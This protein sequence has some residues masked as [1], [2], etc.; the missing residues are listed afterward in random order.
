MRLPLWLL[1]FICLLLSN[2]WLFGQ[3]V[4]LRPF[5]GQHR[6]SMDEPN[7]DMRY[8]INTLAFLNKVSL[9]VPQDL[10]KA[11]IYG[12]EALLKFDSDYFISVGTAYFKDE[13]KLNYHSPSP[14]NAIEYYF[15][16]D[17]RY[18]ELTTGIKYFPHY[19]SWRPI[20][21]Y[22]GFQVGLGVG[23]SRSDFQYR[24]DNPDIDEIDSRGD[25]STNGLIGVGN[26]GFNFRLTG[27]LM[28]N[29]EAG[30][31]FAN[32]GQLEG[33]LKTIN[34]TINN[35]TTSSSYDFSG[36]Y[37]AIGLYF[38]IPVFSF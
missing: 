16:R 28:L 1:I 37:A 19:S 6:L 14:A 13:T 22:F 10:D 25:F 18:F 3:T 23:W 35:Y 38:L 27:W 4:Y 29:G 9:P 11:A 24:D 21:V 17:I 31:R 5:W 20:N 15:F 32:L 36:F 8:R 12:L 33:Q 7:E 26:I 30:Y 2:A 34:A